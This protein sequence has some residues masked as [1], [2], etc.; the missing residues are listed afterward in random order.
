MRLY[1][2]SSFSQTLWIVFNVLISFLCGAS[3]FT[4]TAVGVD[5]FLALKLHL[6]YQALVTPC[7]TIWVIISMWAVSGK[8]SSI[9]L[10]TSGL[11]YNS[12]SP[13]IFT[14]L[15]GNP[16]VYLKRYIIVRR[17]LLQIRHQEHG[18]VHTDGN[19]FNMQRG[20]KRSALNTFL[21][22][23]FML[24]CYLPYSVP[25]QRFYTGIIISLTVR[26]VIQYHSCFTQFYP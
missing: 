8:F 5:H 15:V 6:R 26:H 21:V 13:L 3:I 23:I 18:W 12:L 1:G 2:P 25:L 14:L 9:R 22:Y 16:A 7:R 11:S 20:F 24:F 19:I 17:H 10:W 4:I